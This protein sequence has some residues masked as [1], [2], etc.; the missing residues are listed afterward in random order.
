LLPGFHLDPD[1]V[2]G[3]LGGLRDQLGL[4][5]IP[6]S[7]NQ[8]VYINT[9]DDETN[10]TNFRIIVEYANS[11][12]HAWQSNIQFFVTMATPFLGTQLV[13]ISRQLGVVNEAVDEVR[14]VLDSVFI[15]PS[16]RQTLLINPALLPPAGQQNAELASTPPIYLEDL[17]AW[18]QSFVADEA[19]GVIQSGGRFGLGED[20]SAMIWQLSGLAWATFL[21]AQNVAIP[22][23]LN[24]VRVLTSLQKLAGQLYFLY[25]LAYPVGTSYLQPRP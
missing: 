6:Q 22:P 18:M 19:P 11:L 14:F 7:P 15:G 21:F 20:F 12:W 25:Q 24:T 16:E 5:Q 3:T 23:G 1:T 10:V 8:P 9:I 13:S 17:L 2:H 4:H